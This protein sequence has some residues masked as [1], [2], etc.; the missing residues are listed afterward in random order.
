MEDELSINNEDGLD[1]IHAAIAGAEHNQTENEENEVENV[2]EHS[3]TTG[4][5]AE[6]TG[7]D[8][9]VHEAGHDHDSHDPEETKIENETKYNLHGKRNRS[10][11]HLK[12]QAAS[13]E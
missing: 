8:A 5:D 12:T 13:N 1:G 9:T 7:V 4:V 11:S 3:E 10:Y 2:N 6:I